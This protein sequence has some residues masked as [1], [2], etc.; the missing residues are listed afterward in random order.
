VTYDIIE[1]WSDWQ[2]VLDRGVAVDD[3]VEIPVE[4]HAAFDHHI[5]IQLV[6]SLN[7]LINMNVIVQTISFSIRNYVS[8]LSF[9]EIGLEQRYLRMISSYY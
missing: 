4:R 2:C 1:E 7:K 9:L 5:H 3:L 6:S 8:I